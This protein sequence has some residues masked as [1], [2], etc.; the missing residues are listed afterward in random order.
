MQDL[1][2]IVE[3]ILSY[4]YSHDLVILSHELIFSGVTLYTLL[5]TRLWPRWGLGL[6][7]LLW[8]RV[9]TA[10]SYRNVGRRCCSGIP[11]ALRDSPAPETPRSFG[12]RSAASWHSC[13]C[14]VPAASRPFSGLLYPET[15]GAS[16]SSLPGSSFQKIYTVKKTT[17]VARAHPLFMASVPLKL[18]KV[19]LK[20]H[21]RAAKTHPFW[22]QPARP[23]PQ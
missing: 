16:L 21:L 5:S 14:V 4:Q 19:Y 2:I 9:I 17:P 1:K 10:P 23:A 18:S 20:G 11:T 3:W 6:S 13:H 22:H 8:L 7:L 15:L 12:N